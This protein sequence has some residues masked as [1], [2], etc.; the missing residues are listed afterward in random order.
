MT[1][2]LGGLVGLAAVLPEGV[3]DNGGGIGGEGIR[4]Y[5]KAVFLL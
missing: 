5:L 2:E 1:E 4:G 3:A